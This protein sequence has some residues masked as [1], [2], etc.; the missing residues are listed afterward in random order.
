MAKAPPQTTDAATPE[1]SGG[2][3]KLL[4]IGAVAVFLLLAAG[5]AAF[6]L[7]GGDEP[8]PEQGETAAVAEEDPGEPTY[9]KLDPEFV[10]NLPPGGKAKLL[11]VGLE[12][13]TTD[14]EIT[15]V[16]AR[17]APMLRHHLFDV[18]SSQSA[19]ELFTRAGREHLQEAL[20]EEL[21]N[22]LVAVGES[23]P[24]IKAVYFT[25]FVLQ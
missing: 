11:Q 15:E 8:A 23:E 17:H 12:V 2:R 5:A 19:D 1:K 6:L 21:R 14:P 20:Q 16:L 3:K 10:V 9:Y 13:F 7:L 18:L 25:Q 22:K 4:L 24:N